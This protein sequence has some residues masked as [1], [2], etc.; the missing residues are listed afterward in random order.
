MRVVIEC[1]GDRREYPLP[2]GISVIGR[3][4]EC[5]ICYPNPSLSRRHI[6]CELYGGELTIRDLDTRNGTFVGQQRVSEARLQAGIRVRAGNVWIRF[7]SEESAPGEPRV[8][9]P[10]R[11]AEPLP[12]RELESRVPDAEDFHEEEDATP[13]DTSIAPAAGEAPG[14]TRL[15]VRGEHWFVQDAATGAEVEIVPVRPPAGESGAPAQNADAGMPAML[16]ARVVSGAGMA[17][18]RQ[19]LPTGGSVLSRMSRKRLYIIAGVALGLIVIIAVA[20]LLTRPSEGPPIVPTATYRRLLSEA[21]EKFE[22]GKEVEAMD[23]IKSIQNMRLKN[24]PQLPTILLLAFTSDRQTRENFMENWLSARGRWE[25]VRESSEVKSIPVAEKLAER[26]LEWIRNESVN[27]A[28][29]NSARDYFRAGQYR[30]AL[31]YAASVPAESIFHADGQKLI[32]ESADA[33]IKASL[34]DGAQRRW[35]TAIEGL[36]DVLKLRPEAAGQINPKIAEYEKNMADQNLLIQARAQLDAR[37]FV[38]VLRTLAKIDANSLFAEDAAVVKAAAQREGALGMAQAAF[39]AKQGDKALQILADAG[40]SNGPDAARFKAVMDRREAAF[41]SIKEGKFSVAATQFQDLLRLESGDKNEYAQ[42]AKATLERLPQMTAALS[43]LFVEEADQAALNRDFKTARRK[44]DEAQRLDPAN[45]AAQ[46][47][48]SAMVKNAIRDYNLA[49]SL[50]KNDPHTALQLL[51]DVRDRLPSTHEL[52]ANTETEIL[53][54]KIRMR[55]ETG[56]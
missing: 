18:P 8:S 24:V 56:R 30:Q 1:K 15:V 33:L 38:E 45:R 39:D 54:L 13:L 14:G 46:E 11:Q 44:Y 2:E 31:Q 7:E 42:E 49:M 55:E 47:G 36:R 22:A 23:D 20:S 19:A 10:V 6:E 4:P 26:R 17:A 48:L 9:R 29:L 16:P 5:G 50:S 37:Q 51:E 35:K 21:V 3:D 43:R 25:E 40:L 34:A 12:P 41:Q 27:M 32:P 53:K 28:R 52:H